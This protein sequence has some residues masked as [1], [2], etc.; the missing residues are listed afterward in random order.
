MFSFIS[1][2]FSSVSAIVVRIRSRVYVGFRCRF[3]SALLEVAIIVFFV[4]SRDTI[5]VSLVS[6]AC[7]SLQG[8]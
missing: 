5:L 6:Y 2:C 7:L 3:F 1:Q 4:V 8:Q